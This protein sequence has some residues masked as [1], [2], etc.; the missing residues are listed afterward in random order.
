MTT[1]SLSVGQLASLSGLTAHTIRFYEKA[2]VLQPASRAINGHRRYLPADV[3]WIE[4][5]LRLKVTGM[6][7]TEIKHYAV[8]RAQGDTTLQARMKMLKLH[9][10]SLVKK[11]QQLTENMGGLDSKIR[12]YKLLISKSKA[13]L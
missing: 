4:F 1:Q 10:A 5:V 3:A 9:R 13:T 7:L 12:T 2:G 11:V 8:L 6:S